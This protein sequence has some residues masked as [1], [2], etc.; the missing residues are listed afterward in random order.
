MKKTTLLLLLTTLIST[1][2]MAQGKSKS[3]VEDVRNI[4][5]EKANQLNLRPVNSSY[6]INYQP[7][8]N[9]TGGNFA[10]YINFSNNTAAIYCKSNTEKA[11][12]VWGA[13]YD[14]YTTLVGGKFQY[15]LGAPTSDEFKTP[16]KSSAKSGLI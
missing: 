8:S 15:F 14:K 1:S 10:Y 2:L 5:V 7:L 6:T 13:I 9:E 16:C 12:A 4:I 3:K 11:F